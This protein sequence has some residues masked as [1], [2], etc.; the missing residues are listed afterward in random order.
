[1]AIGRSHLQW[2]E[3]V[4]SVDHKDGRH[5][6]E[7][8]GGVEVGEHQAGNVQGKDGDDEDSFRDFQTLEISNSSHYKGGQDT[9]QIEE[10]L[11]DSEHP[12]SEGPVGLVVDDSDSDRILKLLIMVTFSSGASAGAWRKGNFCLR[13]QKVILSNIILKAPALTPSL[14]K[15]EDLFL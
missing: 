8:V 3:T 5:Q 10:D 1:M 15:Q 12:V 14:F 9:R 4:D 13:M 11:M 7:H 6:D 2:V